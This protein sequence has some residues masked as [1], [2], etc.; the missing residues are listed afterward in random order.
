MN[1]TLFAAAIAASLLAASAARA[2]TIPSPSDDLALGG[3]AYASSTGFGGIP[4]HLNDGDRD[5]NYGNGSI[6]HS[7]DNNTS[8][9]FMGVYFNSPTA[10]N[11]INIFNRTDCC[12][13]RIDGSG[14][15]P[16]TVDL[17][18]GG[19]VGANYTDGT[20]VYSQTFTFNPTISLTAGN[21]D[22]A[23][24]M[25]IFLGG[26]VV[27]SIRITQNFAADM[28]LAE[29]EAFVPEPSSLVLA[30]LGAVA[31]AAGYRRRKVASAAGRGQ[32]C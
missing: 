4:S 26:H 10:I 25:S 32:A 24:G 11:K 17:F 9:E 7:A 27:N 3:V 16:F 1:R 29:L 12:G 19:T 5:G 23:S 8:G 2:A 18:N 15:T 28:N 13:F 30:G 31:L 20:N 21:G 6:A 14:T 22:T